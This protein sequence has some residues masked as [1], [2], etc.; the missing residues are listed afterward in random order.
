MKHERRRIVFFGHVQGVGFR[1]TTVHVCRDLTLGG[2]VRNR[3]DDAVELIVE[4]TASEIDTLVC[5][6]REHF[7]AYVRNVEQ[8]TLDG[9]HAGTK[10]RGIRVIS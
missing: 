4:G 2:T 9:T 10:D 1:M 7:G 3:E 5:R 8:T 6:L